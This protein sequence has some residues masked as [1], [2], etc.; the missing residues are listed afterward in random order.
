MVDE[1]DRIAHEGVAFDIEGL[2]LGT[3]AV[4]APVR[5][6]LGTVAAAISVVA[7][8]GRFGPV[9]R[10]RYA[11]AVKATAASLSAYLGWNP[12]SA[13]VPQAPERRSS[14]VPSQTGSPAR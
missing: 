2:Y 4:G 8:A 14:A 10:S 9:E 12:R 6:Q 5:D 3:C 13:P 11:D 1:L 7:P